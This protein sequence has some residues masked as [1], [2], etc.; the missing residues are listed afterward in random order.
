M[1]SGEQNSTEA[2]SGRVEVRRCEESVAVR[3]PVL[4]EFEAWRV[5]EVT[6]APVDGARTRWEVVTPDGERFAVI[7]ARVGPD[8]ATWTGAWPLP[9]WHGDP[10]ELLEGCR[11]VEE[12]RAWLGCQLPLPPEGDP[13]WRSALQPEA[14]EED[15]DWDQDHDDP[16]EYGRWH[17]PIDGGP[18]PVPPPALPDG[19]ATRIGEQAHRLAGV[20]QRLEV[21]GGEVLA[22]ASWSF[23]LYDNFGV[24]VDGGQGWRVVVGATWA[25]RPA[26][27]AFEWKDW[28]GDVLELDSLRVELHAPAERSEAEPVALGRGFAGVPLAATQSFP[29][30][31]APGSP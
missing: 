11:S 13:A 6:A 12:A 1:T 24:D 2:V 5:A 29:D 26:L 30:T 28:G 22:A 10:G 8:G 14:R 16:N 17:D 3:D 25:G 19:V 7:E 4:G 9:A 27:L 21:A 15:Q 18:W 20:L 31:C 23:S